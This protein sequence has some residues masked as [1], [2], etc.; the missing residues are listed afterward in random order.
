MLHGFYADLKNHDLGRETYTEL[1]KQSELHIVMNKYDSWLNS[2]EKWTPTPIFNFARKKLY[3]EGIIKD[4][5]IDYLKKMLIKTINKAKKYVLLKSGKIYS[6]HKKRHDF[7]VNNN[8]NENHL[9]LNMWQRIPC[10]LTTLNDNLILNEL[11]T[12]FRSNE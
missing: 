3:E 11:N 12:F 6:L 1:L 2:I 8:I 4:L 5:K 9:E 7:K 10:R